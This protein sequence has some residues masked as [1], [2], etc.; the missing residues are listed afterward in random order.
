MSKVKIIGIIVVL[1]LA[2]LAFWPV[3][4]DPVAWQPEPN[5][6]LVGDFAENDGL[7]KGVDLD[8][9]G[10]HGPESV[11]LGPD[12]AV[13]TGTADGWIWRIADG[14][15]KPERWVEAGGIPLGLAF[16]QGGVLYVANALLGLQKIGLDK[17]PISIATEAEGYP[18][19]FADNLGIGADGM[20]YFTDASVKFPAKDFSDPGAASQVEILEH[21]GNGRLLVHNP[22]D[23]TTRAL[24]N[25]LVFANGVAMLPDD[26]SLL[27]NDTG[28]YR[29]LR[30]YY[31]GPQKGQA[32]TFIGNLP[33]FPDNV[34][35]NPDDTYWV[36]LASVDR[37]A[38]DKLAP[39]PG[40]RKV[41]RRIMALLPADKKYGCLVLVDANGKVLK[42]LQ[43]PTGH[44][45]MIT[46]GI[47]AHGMVYASSL[48][49]EFLARIPAAN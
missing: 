7:T 5:P 6:G 41:V 18:V 29:V 43:D 40:L 13:Y 17:K 33:G 25:G 31:Q 28:N 26:Q 22:N 44:R 37:S 16:D 2:Y 49:T 36:G 35:R 34:N 48:E 15:A 46:G 32:V 39:S 27:L 38:A 30:V 23:G 8:L 19:Q 21:R 14:K 1:L 9:D 42:T 47:N 20:I 4:V 24:L 11:A 45:F 3:D 12:G 10:A